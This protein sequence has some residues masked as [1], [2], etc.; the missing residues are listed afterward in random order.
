M[1]RTSCVSAAV[2]AFFLLASCSGLKTAGT[3]SSPA[4]NSGPRVTFASP[5]PETVL[6]LGPVPVLILSED[7]LGTAQVEVLV[8]GIAL[9]TVPSPDAARDSVIVEYVWQPA[10]SGKY[11]LQARA[12]NTAGTWGDFAALEVAIAEAAAGEE[13][14]EETPVFVD[15]PTGEAES[16]DVITT[17]TLSDQTPVLPEFTP[18]TPTKGGISL[19]WSFSALR[20]YPY[21]STCEPRQN[22]V[23][24]S[25]SGMNPAEIGSVMVF[26]RAMH[27]DT[28]AVGKWSNALGLELFESGAYGKGFSSFHFAQ[29]L[30][31]I[32]AV[33]QHMVAVADKGGSVV[34]RSEVYQELYLAPCN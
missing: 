4:V 22:G 7:P 33:I 24:V 2:L 16:T 15:F 14:E 31:F 26:F 5:E 29:P 6:P 11:V 18:V 28:G 21:N 25:V 13:G 30:P 17:P 34:Y 23:I 27:K 3:V 10:A 32:P 1:K 12:Q 9:A 20:M 8:N 19:T